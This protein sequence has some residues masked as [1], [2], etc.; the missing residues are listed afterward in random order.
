MWP[1]EG[2]T[3]RREEYVEEERGGE[4]R[5]ERHKTEKAAHIKHRPTYTAEECHLRAAW[6]VET[7]ALPLAAESAKSVIPS[8]GRSSHR[9]YVSWSAGKRRK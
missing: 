7:A 8:A 3:Q 1:G 6:P 9:R 4:R 2:R 5:G